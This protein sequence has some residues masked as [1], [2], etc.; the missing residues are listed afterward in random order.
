M[1]YIVM[2]PIMFVK[3]F[4]LAAITTAATIPRN[5]LYPS[6]ED[7][8]WQVTQWQAGESHGAPTTPITGWYSFN[9]SGIGFGE[10]SARVP[11]FSAHCEGHA[12]G[13][14][15]SSN[16]SSCTLEAAA[17]TSETSVLSQVLPVMANSQAHISVN[18]LFSTD[19]ESKTKR[20]FTVTIVE[21]WARERPPHN[22]TVTPSEP[23]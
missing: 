15:L 14:P 19:D 9:V 20:N 5:T 16:I 3:T 4:V 1:D 13:K 11:P 17:G 10:G 7:Y 23:A 21:D 12:D 6:S 18:Y 8:I 2:L 22:F